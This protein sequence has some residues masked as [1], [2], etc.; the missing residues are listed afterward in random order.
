MWDGV[1]VVLVGLSCENWEIG[2]LWTFGKMKILV[3][4][5]ELYLELPCLKFNA[6]YTK[7]KMIEQALKWFKFCG[8]PISV[9][10]DMIVGSLVSKSKILQSY[11]ILWFLVCAHAHPYTEI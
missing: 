2:K 11:R 8:N 5:H 9:E 3:N 4:F 10:E 7:W 1:N 6:F